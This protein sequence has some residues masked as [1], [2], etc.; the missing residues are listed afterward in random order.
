[1]DSD[2]LT[3]TGGTAAGSV[4]AIAYVTDIVPPSVTALY[5]NYPGSPANS[6]AP[7]LSEPINNQY[8]YKLGK[9]RLRRLGSS[10]FS[11]RMSF[12]PRNIA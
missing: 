2:V 4:T 8:S 10:E 1:M 12:A 3:Q 6:V 11:E 9:G 7:G 5:F